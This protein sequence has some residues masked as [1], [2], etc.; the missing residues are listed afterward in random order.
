MLYQEKSGNPAAVMQNEDL[1]SKAR[2]KARVKVVQLEVG[3]EREKREF[4]FCQQRKV[5]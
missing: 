5:D 3:R 1:A 2:S 4:E